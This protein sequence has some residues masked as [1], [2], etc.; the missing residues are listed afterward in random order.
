MSLLKK[1]LTGKIIKAYYTVYNKLGSGFLEGVYENAMMIELEK[2]GLYA[3]KQVPIKVLYEKKVLG[4]FYADI[5]VEMEIILELKAVGEL[6]KAHEA[7]LLNYLKGT[8]S[9]IGLLLNFGPK[10]QIVR[11]IFTNDYK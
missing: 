6:T 7:Q 3:E 11:K 8:N 9:E 2:M 5:V 4:K 1:E 10:A